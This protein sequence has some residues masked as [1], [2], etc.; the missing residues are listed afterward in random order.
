MK[1]EEEKLTKS[2]IRA[3]LLKKIKFLGFKT[4][5]QRLAAAKTISRRGEA[6]EM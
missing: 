4:L 6:T 3:G 1:N 5:L 2:E